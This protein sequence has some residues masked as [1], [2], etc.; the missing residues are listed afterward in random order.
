MRRR[1]TN[2]TILRLRSGYTLMEMVVASA[3]S[4]VLIGG[5]ASS[6]YIASQSLD[7]DQ[8]SVGQK[9]QAQ[10][11][12]A[13]ISRDLQSAV[14]LTHLSS[15]S[16]TMT[17]PDRDGDAVPETIRYYWSGTPNESLFQEYNNGTAVAIAENVQAFSLAW[18]TRFIEGVTAVPTLLLVTDEDGTLSAGESERQSLFES[19]GYTVTPLWD[20][21][22]QETYDDAL[23][24]AIG[25]YV[26]SE[27]DAT[28]VAYKLREATVGIVSEHPDLDNEFGFATNNGSGDENTTVSLINVT[29]P[30]T[31]GYATGSQTV[32][33]DWNRITYFSGTKAGGLQ[34]LGQEFGVDSF[35]VLD[36]GATAGQH[37]QQQL[38]GRGSQ[39]THVVW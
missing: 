35:A 24:D 16:V 14:G 27:V 12:L 17:V 26:T 21:A 36:E 34:V 28:D 3:T 33:T 25:V 8:G 32:Y 19:W 22:D 39:G 38:H 11:V 31:T 9:R 29:H 1:S 18:A 6:L 4:A 10:Q 13:M 15:T 7:V 20:G 2:S 5:M 30:I 23:T 37:S